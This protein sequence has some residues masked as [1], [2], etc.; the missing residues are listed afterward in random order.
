MRLIAIGIGERKILNIIQMRL[1]IFVQF[2]FSHV[3]EIDASTNRS[4][5][6]CAASPRTTRPL[7]LEPVRKLP[8]SMRSSAGAVSVPRAR[9]P[10]LVT[11]PSPRCRP[12]AHSTAKD[13]S[14][15][16][17]GR[18]K[19]R[20]ATEDENATPPPD[21]KRLSPRPTRWPRSARRERSSGRSSPTTGVP[22]Q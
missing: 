19:A 11:T 6:S 9:I 13:Q 10:P 21:Q 15:I 4:I 7:A 2:Y 8:S 20:S 14:A 16:P 3:G 1:C 22:L 18:D 5:F 12:H 17:H